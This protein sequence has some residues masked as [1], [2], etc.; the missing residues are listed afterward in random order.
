MRFY[1]PKWALVVLVAAAARAAEESQTAMGPVVNVVLLEIGAPSAG[2]I[3]VD[4]WGYWGN[5]APELLKGLRQVGHIVSEGSIAGS[6]FGIRTALKTFQEAAK[7]PQLT[8]HLDRICETTQRPSF[9]IVWLAVK[10]DVYLTYTNLAELRAASSLS[11]LAHYAPAHAHPSLVPNSSL[12]FVSPPMLLALGSRQ[13]KE[14]SLDAELA[15]DS[16]EARLHHILQTLKL[17]L[18]EDAAMMELIRSSPTGTQF[19]LMHFADQAKSFAQA[20]LPLIA[21]SGIPGAKLAASAPLVELSTKYGSA[22]MFQFVDSFKQHRDYSALQRAYTF[23]Q[24]Y[25]KTPVTLPTFG[26]MYGPPKGILFR[27]K[28]AV[29]IDKSGVSR[30]L[31]DKTVAAVKGKTGAEV[32]HEDENLIAV[33]W[34]GT[35]DLFRVRVGTFQSSTVDMTVRAGEDAIRLVRSYDSQ[36]LTPSACGLDWTVAAYGLEVS[37]E[38]VRVGDLVAPRHVFFRDYE[39]GARLTY[40]CDV[41]EA[42]PATADAR[43]AVVGYK[44]LS[45]S[46]QPELVFS[47]P[48]EFVVVFGDGRQLGF[49]ASGR[50]AWATSRSGQRT[51]YDYDGQRLARIRLA[52]SIITLTYEDGQLGAAEG[53]DGQRVLYAYDAAGRLQTVEHSR[54]NRKMKY[55]YD[56]NGRLTAVLESTADNQEVQAIRRNTYDSRGR[57]LTAEEADRRVLF[58]YDDTVGKVTATDSLGKRATYFY[59]GENRLA[60]FGPDPDHMTLLNH[61][62]SGRLLQV[63]LGKLTNEAGKGHR[64]EFELGEV[65]IPQIPDSE[66]HHE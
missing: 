29:T 30:C 56:E 63:S 9:V 33:P 13:G 37:S 46:F 50:L 28:L 12:G 65:V 8:T 38:V 31:A 3:L 32:I 42:S 43:I 20:T 54:T 11:L 18:I 57:V 55:T 6:L 1:L 14:Q 36:R 2:D 51:L 19:D 7:S 4:D 45:S 17:R 62:I 59:D 10:G 44:R 64:P 26:Q 35:E 48:G 34:P 27:P 40:K 22:P 47:E 21:A 61:D 58:D 53:S 25:F 49:D 39:L 52:G 5:T 15:F 24:P 60:A 16:A 23:Y 66:T 41:S